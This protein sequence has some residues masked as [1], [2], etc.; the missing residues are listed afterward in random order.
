VLKKGKSRKYSLLRHPVS[1]VVVLQRNTLVVLQQNGRT[2]DTLH[3]VPSWLAL[4]ILKTNFAF[5]AHHH[6]AEL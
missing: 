3:P 6:F 5:K 1:R 2:T 4:S